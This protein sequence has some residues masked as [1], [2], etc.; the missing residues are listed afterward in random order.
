MKNVII[1][2]ASGFGREVLHTI[3]EINKV[4][5]AYHVEGFI[6]D[7]PNALA[8]FNLE[9]KVL[10]PIS[11]WVPKETDR[12]VL[13]IADPKTKEKIIPALKEKG[14]RFETVIAPTASVAEGAQ[15]GEGVVVFG[16]SGISINTRIGNFAFFNAMGGIGH[17]VVIGD[18]C[19][20]GPKV[21]IS[22][23]TKVGR[24]VN[25]GAMSSTYPGITIGDYATVGMNSAAIRRVKPNTTVIGVPAKEI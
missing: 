9:Y 24:C 3:G 10:G 18:Y 22:G 6:D 2:G 8:G 19:T 20:F 1:V 15:L 7:N 25:F 14:A 11:G 17:D 13:A 23:Y 4:N 5:P 16:Y 12:Y 21:C